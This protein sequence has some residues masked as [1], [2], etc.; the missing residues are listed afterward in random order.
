M[1]TIPKAVIIY[2]EKD[3]TANFKEV[4]HYN[5]IKGSTLFSEKLNIGINRGISR[6]KYTYSL[7]IRQGNKWSKQI[8]GLFPTIMEGVYFGD[9]N[10]KSNLVVVQFSDD[11]TKLRLHF[12]ENFYT[13]H[14]TNFLNQYFK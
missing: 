3:E 5:L 13:R 7:K 10:G 4:E 2:F 6:A 14:T 12:F 9:T 11:G 8:T 1:A